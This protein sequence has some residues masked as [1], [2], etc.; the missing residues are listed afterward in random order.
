MNQG[1]SSCSSLFSSG[2]FNT[3]LTHEVG[4]S[5]GFRHSDG[6]RVN[7]L[8]GSCSG[9][10]NLECSTTPVMKAFLL[11]GINAT[12]Q[13]WDIHAAATVYP[14]SGVTPP[15]APVITATAANSTSVTVS[16]SAVT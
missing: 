14:G 3:A 15:A 10:P 9:D 8:A 11:N 1:L 7:Q 13:T 4:H 5:L 2:N 12:L 6:D 16:W